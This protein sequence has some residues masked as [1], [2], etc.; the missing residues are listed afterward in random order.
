MRAHVQVAVVVLV[1]MVIPIRDK[2]S[3]TDYIKLKI[4]AALLTKNVLMLQLFSVIN[5]EYF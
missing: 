5:W 3:T 1:A 2:L 4:L